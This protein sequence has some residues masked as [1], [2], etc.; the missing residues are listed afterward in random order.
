MA[1]GNTQRIPAREGWSL[2]ARTVASLTVVV[3]VGAIAA[4]DYP[5]GA[6]KTRKALWIDLHPVL[7]EAL[8]ARLG[9]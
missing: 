2:L 3:G 4:A 9:P 6:T 1:A 5:A 7:A 8:E